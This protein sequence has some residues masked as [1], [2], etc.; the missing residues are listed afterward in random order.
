MTVWLYE[1]GKGDPI[2]FHTYD[3][4]VGQMLKRDGHK[5]IEEFFA[6]CDEWDVH[7]EYTPGEYI[8][9]DD[10]PRVWEIEYR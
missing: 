4:A 9:V 8:S 2:A 1:S 3:D 5:T 7:Y 6:E 10:G